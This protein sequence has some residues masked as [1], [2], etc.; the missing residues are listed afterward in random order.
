M[1]LI[2]YT[3]NCTGVR[4]NCLY[5]NRVVITDKDG[6]CAAIK[7]DHVAAKYKDNYRSNDNFEEATGIFMDN[8]NDHEELTQL[9]NLK[10][11]LKDVINQ[12]E[13]KDEQLVLRYR[14]IYNWTWAQI[15]EEIY[16]DERTVRRW[17]NKA[18]AHVVVPANPT[19]I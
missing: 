19:I 3:A 9:L 5:P 16:A 10:E 4:S 1:E 12:V 11:E 2:L 17:H 8:D 6:L 15:G 18:L 7:F 14:Y 13:D